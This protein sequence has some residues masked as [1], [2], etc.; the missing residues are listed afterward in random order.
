MPT[1]DLLYFAWFEE[2]IAGAAPKFP[3][4]LFRFDTERWVA[5]PVVCEPRRAGTIAGRLSLPMLVFVQKN[6]VRVH[7]RMRLSAAA[8]RS[9]VMRTDDR[10]E[11]GQKSA[12]P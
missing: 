6:G 7:L 3:A 11:P 9:V 2:I 12:G 1:D 5:A 4:A 8:L 10:I